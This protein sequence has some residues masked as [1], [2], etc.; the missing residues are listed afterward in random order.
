MKLAQTAKV[1]FWPILKPISEGCRGWRQDKHPK[2]KLVFGD[3]LAGCWDENEKRA[4]SNITCH[5]LKSWWL[6]THGSIIVQWSEKVYSCCGQAKGETKTCNRQRRAAN[7]NGQREGPISVQTRTRV[8][9]G[10]I[11]PN[12]KNKVWTLIPFCLFIAHVGIRKQ[13]IRIWYVFMV[14]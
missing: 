9:H 5:Q 12:K 13:F 14:T 7:E 6:A 4:K 8:L 3:L 11:L 2:W 10:N 1:P